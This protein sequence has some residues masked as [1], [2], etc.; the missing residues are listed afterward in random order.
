MAC[1]SVTRENVPWYVVNIVGDGPLIITS[2]KNRSYFALHKNT[3][4][5]AYSLLKITYAHV[6]TGLRAIRVVKLKFDVTVFL[7]A[8]S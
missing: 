7:V 1:D 6:I 4:N 3:R 5:L 2:L 8:S